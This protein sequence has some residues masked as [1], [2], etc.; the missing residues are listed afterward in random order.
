[1][2]KNSGAEWMRRCACA[3]ALTESRRAIGVLHENS[4]ANARVIET[5]QEAGGERSY[6]VGVY[7]FS[8]AGRRFWGQTGNFEEVGDSVSVVY[9][10]ANPELNH[11]IGEPS[12]FGIRDVKAALAVL[13]SCYTI[14]LAIR[15]IWEMQATLPSGNQTG[16]RASLLRMKPRELGGAILVALVLYWLAGWIGVVLAAFVIA[17]YFSVPLEQRERDKHKP[18][19]F[20]DTPYGEG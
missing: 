7:E 16:T 18:D 8:V 9:N 14:R 17:S 19:S 20:Y 11:G 15:R 3:F 12:G 4:T 10:P 5:A 1:M 6:T 13:F 2:V